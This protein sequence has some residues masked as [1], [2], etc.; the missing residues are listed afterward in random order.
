MLYNFIKYK[1]IINVKKLINVY[2][3]TFNLEYIILPLIYCSFSSS[4][5]NMPTIR[6]ISIEKN[7]VDD[8]NDD[9]DNYW[10]RDRGKEW[11]VERNT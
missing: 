10:Y 5:F 2:V 8:D 6:P 9:D 7:V 11:F 1:Y 3:L 4:K